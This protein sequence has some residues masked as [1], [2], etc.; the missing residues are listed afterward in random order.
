MGLGKLIP[1]P[2]LR[3]LIKSE[4]SDGRK[5]VLTNG[6]FD[7]LH[8]GHIYLLET[9]RSFG[10]TLVVALNTDNSIRQL[11]GPGRPI[12][13][14]IIRV[15]NL[16]KLKCVDYITLFDDLL[17]MDVITALLPDILV[18]GGDYGD[19]KLEFVVGK[20]FVESYKG[21]VKIVPLLKDSRGVVYSTTGLIGEMKL[22][23]ANDYMT[24]Q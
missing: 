18:K 19:D 1:T 12:N 4:K 8:D 9:A 22:I 13:S 10:D 2:T 14:E 16:S 24:R 21:E 5:I 7:L 20:C 6:C 17:P 3:K 15:D 11:K 23:A